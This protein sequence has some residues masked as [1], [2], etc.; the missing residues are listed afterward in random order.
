MDLRAYY[1]KLRQIEADIREESVVITSLATPDG[2][3]AGVRT[4]VPRAVAARM[5]L[6]EKAELASE[7]AAA[8]FRAEAERK[9]K[10]AH[11]AGWRT[12]RR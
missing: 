2:G 7:K 5:I 1:Q 11:D 4:E 10:A 9:W 6:E 8:E 3:R 12:K